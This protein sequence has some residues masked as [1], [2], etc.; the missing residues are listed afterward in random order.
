MEEPRVGG[1][2]GEHATDEDRPFEDDPVVDQSVLTR[3][4]AQRQA[5]TEKR[6]LDIPIPGY[7]LTARYKAI[8]YETVDK[9][10]ERAR[11]A[12]QGI[13]SRAD[14]NA[15]ADVLARS[16]LAIFE[17]GAGGKLVPLNELLEK[18]GDDPICYDERLAEAVGTEGKKAREVIFNVFAVDEPDTGNDMVLMGHQTE[19]LQWLRQTKAEV[20]ADF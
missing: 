3:L 11:K 9:I 16:C 13:G 1:E 8:S 10:Q 2:E 4:R 19:I 5:L 7:E 6:T 15:A 18:W 17:R 14:L 20:D 12:S